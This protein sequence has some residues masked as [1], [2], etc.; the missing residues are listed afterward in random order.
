MDQI[1]IVLLNIFRQILKCKR[2]DLVPCGSHPCLL[3]K[4]EEIMIN[5]EKH[6]LLHD[7]YQSNILFYKNLKSFLLTI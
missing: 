6:K 4:R 1:L 5:S 7:Y 3:I 2:G